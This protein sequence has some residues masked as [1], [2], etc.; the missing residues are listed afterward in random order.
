MTI[1][2]VWKRSFIDL[3]NPILIPTA[4]EGFSLGAIFKAFVAEYSIECSNNGYISEERG[5]RFSIMNEGDMAFFL[6]HS[7]NALWVS[8]NTFGVGLDKENWK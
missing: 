1:S 4:R 5:V 7:P 8:P 6:D 3:P 2:E